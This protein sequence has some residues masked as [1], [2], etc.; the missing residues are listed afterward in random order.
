MLVSGLRSSWETCDTKSALVW[1]SACAWSSIRRWSSSSCLRSVMS[2]PAAMIPCSFPP[3]SVKVDALMES[4]VVLP[5][6]RSAGIS[7]LA[8]WPSRSVWLTPSATAAG[9]GL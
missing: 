3:L 8:R 2:R 7:M 4:T 5:S 6:G 1:S 9:S